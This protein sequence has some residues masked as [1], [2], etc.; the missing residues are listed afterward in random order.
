MKK[1]LKIFAF[2]ALTFFAGCSSMKLEPV[3]YAWPI[4]NVL[5]IRSDFNVKSMRYAITLNL[6]EVF[7]AEKMITNNA[8]KVKQV[9]IIRNEAGYYFI[10][11]NKFKRV[12]VFK[13]SDK[14]LVL[15][16]EIL[17]DENGISEPAFNQ[18]NSYIEL[19]TD[20]GKYKLTQN[21][22]IN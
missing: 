13:P 10:T 8:P 16:T 5:E 2:V 11:A 20:K 21:G 14:S 15:Q 19:I 9:R 17:I 7:R 18:R 4:E 3:N 22:I 1:G 12:Y 6:R